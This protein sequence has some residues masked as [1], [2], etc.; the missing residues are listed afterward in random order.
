MPSLTAIY[1]SATPAMGQRFY[2]VS[3]RLGMSTKM[4]PLILISQVAL[5]LLLLLGGAIKL[6]GFDVIAIYTSALMFGVLARIYL[7]YRASSQ[8]Y[9]TVSALV[10]VSGMVVVFKCTMAQQ[11][12]S[13][14]GRCV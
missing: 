10:L 2:D 8:F 5:I 14:N 12:S 6:A 7:F 13:G 3:G 4:Q 9:S 1:K 11:N